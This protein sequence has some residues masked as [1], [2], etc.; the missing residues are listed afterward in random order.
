ML[1]DTH[2]H[3]FKE[4]YDDIDEVVERAKDAGV[5]MIVVNGIDRKTNEEVLELVKKYDI[6]YGALGIQT[7]SIET[8]SQEDFKF[9]E[10]HINDERIVAVGEIG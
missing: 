10:K 8:V 7:E 1:I 4:Y 6:V 5:S 9:I 2:C 3:L